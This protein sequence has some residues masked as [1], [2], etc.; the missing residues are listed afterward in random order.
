M[1]VDSLTAKEKV[2]SVSKWLDSSLEGHSLNCIVNAAGGFMMDDI[3]SPD[4]Y[5]Q[6]ETMWSWNALSAFQCGSIASRY[7]LSSSSSLLVLTGAAAAFGPTPIMLSYGTS[8]AV[9][10]HL[11]KTLSCSESMPKDAKTIGIVPVTIDTPPNREAM[12]SMDFSDWTKPE[13]FAQQIHE[14]ANGN[15][16]VNGGL[17]Q[18]D[19]KQGETTITL[20]DSP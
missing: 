9:V 4:F 6:L 13:T 20:K 2:E 10:H 12:P 17:Y 16:L 11:V 7:L 1:N 3:A 8:K 19:T 18:F 14:W 5:D 15:T